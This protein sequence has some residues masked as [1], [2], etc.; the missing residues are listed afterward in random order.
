MTSPR[1][2]VKPCVGADDRL[3]SYPPAAIIVFIR[4]RPT[5]PLPSVLRTDVDE[6]EIPEHRADSRARFFSQQV[7]TFIILLWCTIFILIVSRWTLVWPAWKW[8]PALR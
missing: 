2:N 8:A 1:Q 3:R 4:K 5:R 7:H 6:N